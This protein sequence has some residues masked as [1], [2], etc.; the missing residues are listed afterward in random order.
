MTTRQPEI[1]LDNA[2]TSY[3][4]PSCVIEAITSTITSTSLS[5]GRSA[6]EFSLRA[7]RIIFE[8]RETVADFFGCRDSSRVIFT[9]NVTEAL[10]YGLHGLL[11][12]GDHVITT[13]LE[14]NSVMRPL[15][16]L[17]KKLGLSISILPTT[18]KGEILSDDLPATLRD[19]T[20]LIIVNHVSNV[21]G[22]MA[23]IEHISR[24][25]GNALLMV[26]A[27]QS[28]GIFPIDIEKLDIDFL[29]FTGHKALFGPTGTGGFIL[30]KGIDITPLKM[31]GTGSNSEFEEQP[32]FSPDCYEAGTPNTLGIAGLAAGIEFIRQTGI[33]TIRL[34]EQ[35]L[36]SQLLDGL[37]R[38]KNIHV[39]APRISA[40]RSAVVSINCTGKSP[41]E[42]SLQL[43]RR[44]GIMVR[45]GLHC[46]PSAHRAI[47]TF[48]QGTLRISCGY[49]N[50]SRDISDCLEALEYIS[51]H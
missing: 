51:G 43:D 6:H 3:P 50:T 37:S 27:A 44:F 12:P 15:R 5:P 4:K 35:K 13:G 17:E 38:I 49:F 22:T 10:N 20:R 31:G 16:H 24:H 28:A 48:P 21:T 18:E 7:G 8:A 32:R 33:D 9:S 1:Y 46:S 11:R 19:N 23:P 42:V 36:L 29:A 40:G 45:P 2:A 30:R 41:S 25:K 14:H 26:D 47:G 34:H 39:Y